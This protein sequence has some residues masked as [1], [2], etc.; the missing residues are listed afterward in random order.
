VFSKNSISPLEVVVFEGVT[1][2][3]KNPVINIFGWTLLIVVCVVF[4]FIGFSPNSNFLG[5]GGAAAQVNGDAISLREF[6]ELLDRLDSG[7]Q[8]GTSQEAQRKMKENALDIL[9]SRSL[10]VQEANRLNIHVSDY[11]VAQELK[12]IESFYEDGIFS[13]F[14]YKKYLQQARMTE[15]EFEGRIRKDLV[16]QKMSE[17]IGFAAKDLEMMDQFDETIDKAQVNVG[18]VKLSPN[19]LGKKPGNV[20]QWANDNREKIKTYYTNHKSEFTIPEQVKARH[21][22][23]KSSDPSPESMDVALQQIKEIV[24]DLTVD[25]FADKAKKHSDDPGSKEKGGDLGFFPRGRMV[26]EFEEVAFSAEKGQISEPVKTQYGYH[27]ILVE[28]KKQEREESLD[29][30]RM[31]IAR[32]LLEEDVFQSS[33]DEIK[34]MLKEKKFSELEAFVA[35]KGLRWSSTGFFGITKESVPGVGANQDFMDLALTLGPDKEYGERLVYQ[36]ESAYLLKYKGAKLTEQVQDN[37]QMD[38]FKQLMKQQ[39]MNTLVK[40]WTDSLRQ[41][42][43]IKINPQVLR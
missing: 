2:R 19:S 41:D 24:E 11:E 22:L 38:F 3:R 8:A 25:N 28:D 40:N 43:A 6:K 13:R 16:I 15:G 30:V 34:Q 20:T 39:K 35:N 31:Q 33:L 1:K 7:R 12:G 21:I 42:A 18:Y 5:R 37:P 32:Q 14:L 29:E 27:V 23:I 17:L 4:V 10:I 26:P 9:V 36:G